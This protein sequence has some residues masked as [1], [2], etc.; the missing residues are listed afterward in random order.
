MQLPNGECDTAE[1]CGHA[2]STTVHL[3]LAP[4]DDIDND[5]IKNDVDNCP[6]FPNG[7]QEDSDKDG[8]GDFCAPT[9]DS[10]VVIVDFNREEWPERHESDN[11]RESVRSDCS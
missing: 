7:G 1:V 11:L 9:P 3:E 8:T 4:P 10:P 6:A 5:S 2:S